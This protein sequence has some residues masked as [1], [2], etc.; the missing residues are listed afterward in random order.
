MRLVA[1]LFWDEPTMTCIYA[2]EALDRTLKDILG[3][4]M[5]FGGK[6]IIFG[7]VLDKFYQLY[8]MIRYLID[9]CIVKSSLKIYV[10]VIHL[11]QHM[12]AKEDPFYADPYYELVMKMSHIYVTT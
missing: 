7:G 5:S 9:V 11:T 4:D 10:E 8:K 1:V 6:V 3:N 12:R 2:F